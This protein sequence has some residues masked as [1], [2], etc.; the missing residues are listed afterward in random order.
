MISRSTYLFLLSVILSKCIYS[1][2]DPNF[3]VCSYACTDTGGC[4]VQFTGP[5]RG[6]PTFGSCFP[7]SFGGSCNG[8]PPE[9][10]DCNQVLECSAQNKDGEINVNT[11]DSD[12][13]GGDDV[14]DYQCQ[15]SGGCQ[16]QFFTAF[17]KLNTFLLVK[18]KTANLFLSLFSYIHLLEFKLIKL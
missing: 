12:N 17:T 3:D 1:E 11:D 15:E 5:P 13:I 14:C 16:V 18:A 10:M 2:T 7:A 6:G 8:I 9:C 4:N